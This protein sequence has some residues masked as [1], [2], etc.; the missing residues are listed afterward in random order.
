MAIENIQEVKI[1]AG[2]GNP[3]EEYART[4]HN[5]GA[6]AVEA[7]VPGAAWK[8]HGRFRY[9]KESGIIFIIPETFMNESGLAVL[10]ALRF[11]KLKPNELLILHDDSDLP[12]GEWKLHFGRGSAGHKGV[13][14]VIEH[15]G[16]EDLWRARIGIRPAEEERRRKAGDFVLDKI[17][18]PDMDALEKVFT[19]IR[20]A[21]L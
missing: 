10:E 7:L 13:A 19:E 1:A 18:R 21:L 2:L 11:F 5:A 12:I 16:T 20:A 4:Y 6:L 15:I 3:G 14:S 17:K 8:T 9:A